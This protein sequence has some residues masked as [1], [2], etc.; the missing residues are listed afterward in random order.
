MKGVPHTAPLTEAQRRLVADYRALAVNRAVRQARRHPGK[1][2]R[3]HDRAIDSLLLA[4]RTFDPA[5]GVRFATYLNYRLERDF[6]T[7]HRVLARDDR[8]AAARPVPL[9]FGPQRLSGDEGTGRE[10][11]DPHDGP[12]EWAGAEDFAARVAPLTP[13]ERAVVGLLYRDG[14][15]A[16]EAARRLGISSSEVAR[17][18]DLALSHLRHARRAEVSPR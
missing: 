10:P 11:P 7:L 14:L 2:D 9:P 8:H 6:L 4:A 13:P 12:S 1:A 5:R 17:R 18:R 16:V 15:K 3:Y